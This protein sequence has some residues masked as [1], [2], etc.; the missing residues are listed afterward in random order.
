MF[1]ILLDWSR[2]KFCHLPWRQ[3]HD[4]YYVLVSEIMLQQTTVGTVINH[5]D[6]FIAKFPTIFS[7]AKATDHEMHLAWKGLGYYRRAKNLQNA[8]KE[9]VA[10]YK[11]VIP[12]SRDQLLSIK[13]IGPYTCEAIMAFAYDEKALALDANIE[14]VVARYFGIDGVKGPKFQKIIYEKFW[15]KEIFAGKH[16]WRNLNSAL[17]DLGRTICQA[18][19]ADCLLCP[20]KG[21]CVSLK[22]N[23]VLERPQAVLK[24]EQF[25]ELHLVRLISND[26]V[27]GYQKKK[28]EWLEGQ[29]ELPTFVISTDDKVFKQYPPKIFKVDKSKVIK[30]S[31]TKYKI[32]NYPLEM[33][34]AELKKMGFKK[35][36]KSEIENLS[37]ASQKI[38]K[39]I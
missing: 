1:K 5:Y 21:E 15:K 29:F 4:A 30:T 12:K 22:E 13:G 28:G 8:A 26:G 18:R 7:L 39:K 23:K 10:K 19:K 3:E 9:I 38:L 17:M 6:K 14:R 33:S 24:K 27:Y 25:F 20:L 36:N 16:P 11:G 37:T 2:Q 31:I 32:F 35:L 34:I